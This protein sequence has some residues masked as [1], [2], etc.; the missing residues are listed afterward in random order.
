MF[1][2]VFV[3]LQAAGNDVVATL[4]A[5][6]CL[7]AAVQAATAAAPAKRTKALAAVVTGTPVVV[8]CIALFTRCWFTYSML[9]ASRGLGLYVQR[10]TAPDLESTC[11]GSTD[12]YTHP[13]IHYIHYSAILC[14]RRS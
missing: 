8:S 6:A 9:L 5:E 2:N 10:R 1:A 13:S 11:V 7:A 12:Q 3:V 4:M 14:V